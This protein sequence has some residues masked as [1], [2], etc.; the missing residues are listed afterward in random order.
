MSDTL[1]AIRADHRN[2]WRV[3]EAMGNVIRGM[4][5]SPTRKELDVVYAAIYYMRVYPDRHHHPKEE[6]FLFTALRAAYPASATLLGEIEAEHSEGEALLQRVQSELNHLEEGVP[7][8]RAALQAVA[9]EYIHM[10]TQHIKREER[11]V[12]PLAERYL[13]ESDWVRIDAA[14]RADNDP[15][16][17]NAVERGFEALTARLLSLASDVARAATVP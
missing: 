14:F 8:S 2:F 6:N 13:G 7:Q 3:L 4:G 11:E 1:D 9:D 17:R 16:F 10:Q 12:L 15:L 5:D